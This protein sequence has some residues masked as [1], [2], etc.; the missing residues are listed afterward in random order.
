MKILAIVLGI[1]LMLGV[2]T[3]VFVYTKDAPEAVMA[4]PTNFMECAVRYPV[5]ESYPRQCNTPTGLHFVEEVPSPPAPVFGKIDDL[6]EVERPV[7][8]QQI[9]SPLVIT[10]RAR[11]VWFFEATFPIELKN[12]AG[13]VIATH[14]AEAE[15][16][17]MTED[18]VPFS[19]TL[20]FPAQPAG[21]SGSLVLK[22]S[23]AS[24]DPIRDQE[25][26]I[27]VTF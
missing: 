23:N 17:W 13:V 14:Y 11:G 24:G 20:T 18:F 4:E 27:P 16:E 26:V 10:G 3:A 1:V 25:L 2:I 6:I 12:A 8:N 19:A 22:R 21:T 7:V 15:D 5:M 9:A